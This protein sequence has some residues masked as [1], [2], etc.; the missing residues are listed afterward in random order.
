VLPVGRGVTAEAADRTDVGHRPG[1]LRAGGPGHE[2][3]SGSRDTARQGVSGAAS[4]DLADRASG[5]A[6]RVDERI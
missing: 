1:H 4:R 5:I 3:R 6:E 2:P